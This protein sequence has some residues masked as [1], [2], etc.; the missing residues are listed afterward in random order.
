MKTSSENEIR[1]DRF[2]RME[3]HPDFHP[4]HKRPFSES[5]LEYLCKFW[6]T[7][8]RQ[9]MA[10]ALG[11]TEHTLGVKVASLKK[12]GLYEYYKSLNKHW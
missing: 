11:R 10:F 9:T 12:R 2:G 8:H 5:D 4:N 7:D 6:E 1:Y 3:Y